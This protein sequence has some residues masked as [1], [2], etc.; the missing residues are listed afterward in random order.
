MK[1]NLKAVLLVATMALLSSACQRQGEAP[2]E[3]ATPT[4]SPAAAE[5]E[6]IP[7]TLPVLDALLADKAFKADLKSKLQLTDEQIA[8]LGKISSEAVTKLRHAN[9][10]NQP[11]SAE[12]SRQNAIEA[13]RRVIGAEKSE[14][15]LALARDRWNKGSEEIEATA[16]KDTEPT[17]LKGPNAIPKDTRVVVNIPAYR[18]DVFQNGSLIKSYKVGIGYPEFP[19]PQGLRKAQMI[20]FNPTWTPPDSPWVDSMAVTPGEVIAAGSKQNPLGPI[21]IPIGSPSLIHGGKPLAKIGTFA[22]HGCVGMTNGQVKDFAK[23]LAQAS[24]TELSDQTM[25]AYLKNRTKTRTVK[26]ANLVPVELRYET[27]VVEDG[28]LHIYRDVYDQNTNTEENLR[29]VLQANGITFEDLGGEEKAQV[30][31]ALNAMSR[32]PKKQPTPK[33]SVV[34]NQNTADKLARAAERRAEAERQKKL[35]NRKEIVIEIALL[36]GKGYP[37]PANLDSGTGTQV[38]GVNSPPPVI[39][40]P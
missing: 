2:R 10:E 15:L 5:V 4:S 34:G 28:K 35:R 13:I 11:G 24:Q 26:L 30:L 8:A 36:T 29:A 22:S 6:T 33:P 17:M 16:P 40:R 19:L 32:N 14:Q 37:P 39:V 18:M 3:V 7:I 20:I 38:A 23:L 25:A 27:I 21:K 31:D 9:A 1:R 12:T